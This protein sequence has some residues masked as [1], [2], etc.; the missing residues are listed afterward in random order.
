[1]GE[2]ML[3]YKNKKGEEVEIEETEVITAIKEEYEKKLS[4]RDASMIK[5][6]NDFEKEKE[7]MRQ[8]HVKQ[9][10]AILTGRKE[11][12]T[13]KQEFEEEE[14]TEEELTLESAKNYLGKL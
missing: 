13:D 8:E 11:D 12:V 7:N 4:E 3:K 10:R 2:I 6:K 14:K 9:M 1:M 5:L